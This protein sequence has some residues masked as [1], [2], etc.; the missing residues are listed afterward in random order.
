MKT[1]LCTLK[2]RETETTRAATKASTKLNWLTAITMN[3]FACVFG[4]RWVCVCV[5]T[6]I[7][8]SIWSMQFVVVIVPTP[9]MC[10]NIVWEFYATENWKQ[11]WEQFFGFLHHSTM[12][13]PFKYSTYFPCDELSRHFTSSCLTP[14]LAAIGRLQSNRPFTKTHFGFSNCVRPAYFCFYP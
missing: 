13:R 14:A 4:G 6:I 3:V 12:V 2:C 1:I 10:T 8:I 9:T 5:Y 11:R 7:R